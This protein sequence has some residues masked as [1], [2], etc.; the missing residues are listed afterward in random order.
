MQLSRDGSFR[1]DMQARQAGREPHR[2]RRRDRRARSPYTCRRG[3][4]LARDQPVQAAHPIGGHLTCF[5]SSTATSSASFRPHGGP[6]RVRGRGVRSRRHRPDGHKRGGDPR[7]SCTADVNMEEAAAFSR[8]H[9]LLDSRIRLPRRW[10]ARRRPW[11][12]G[13]PRIAKLGGLIYP[14]SIPA[15]RTCPGKSRFC[16]STCYADTGFFMMENVRRKHIENLKRTRESS[17]VDDAVVRDQVSLHHRRPHTHG[18]RLS[19]RLPTAGNGRRSS[20]NVTGPRSSA[21]RGAGHRMISCRSW[22]NWRP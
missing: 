7:R 13:E 1:A 14:F 19:T 12:F 8:R 9:S 18:R 15:K 4:S 22:R 3:G 2:H 6:V 20:A 5:T 11:L 17:F 21:T 10:H 16:A